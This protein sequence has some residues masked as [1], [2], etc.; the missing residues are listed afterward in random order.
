MDKR[1]VAMTL[2]ATIGLSACGPQAFSLTSPDIEPNGPFRDEQVFNTAGCRGKNVSPA[3]EWSGAPP[4]AKSFA[5]TIYDPDPAAGNG[6]WHWA[7][8]DIPAEKTGLAKGAG[9][10]LSQAAPMGSAQVDNDFG[11]R[12]YGGPC[13]P[14][15]DRPHRYQITIYALDV[16]K[17][18]AGEDATAADV[19]FKLRAHALSKAVLTA[20]DGR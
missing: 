6:F 5:V 3:L 20:V 13:P 7:I 18:D 4:G 11:V 16:D 2:A 10:P 8:F 17:L 14:V 19:A 15:G 12:G 1:F 9:D